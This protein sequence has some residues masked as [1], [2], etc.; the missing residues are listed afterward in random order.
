MSHV[1][2]II[3]N[4]SSKTELPDIVMKAINANSNFASVINVKSEAEYI[5]TMSIA[6]AFIIRHR[7][8]SGSPKNPILSPLV[9]FEIPIMSNQDCIF[10]ELDEISSLGTRSYSEM[11]LK[12]RITKNRL[13]E[14]K[15]Y[16]K[17]TESMYYHV[18]NG[19]SK[20]VASIPAP[21]RKIQQDM[22][23]PIVLTEL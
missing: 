23:K 22:N 5:E 6:D 15:D 12:K 9:S 14:I 1:K 21:V 3:V 2:Y 13:T 11:S 17:L 4:I 7:S 16:I 20:E 8:T 18:V 10:E 19:Q